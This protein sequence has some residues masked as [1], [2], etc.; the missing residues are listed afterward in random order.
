MA[1]AKRQETINIGLIVFRPEGLDVRMLEN[2]S[3]I[4]L[5]DS[6]FDIH[7][8]QALKE[9]YEFLCRNIESPE[10]QLETLNLFKSRVYVSKPGEF[11]LDHQNQ[12]E[13]K[14]I[15]LFKQL[16]AQIKA[17][18][19][20]TGKSKF[21]TSLKNT[22]KDL[23]LLANTPSE[24]SQHKIVHNYHINEESGITADFLLKN[25]AFHLTETIDYDVNIAT[26]KLRETSLK[27]MTF[28][29]GQRSLDGDV[30]NYF[31]YKASSDKELEMSAQINLARSHS[32]EV[33]NF[34]S[35]NDK[36]KYFNII[37]EAIGQELQ[38]PQV[39]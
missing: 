7:Q 10:T 23:K 39:H 19:T 16:V 37:S 20:H 34:S 14:I 18:S 1:D 11:L 8:I 24:L 13:S 17:P 32:N 22:F 25:G 29:E 33:F 6:N 27:L 21:T 5:F 9:Q 26:A 2:I 38:L 4:R 31:V 28:I 3:K 12:Y 36:D 35:D 30:K 15:S